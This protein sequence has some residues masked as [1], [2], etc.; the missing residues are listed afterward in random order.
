MAAVEADHQD[1]LRGLG[2]GFDRPQFVAAQAQR[3]FH[4][5]VLAAFQRLHHIT[6]V[7]VVAGGDDDGV[8]VGVVEHP[9]RV[10]IRILSPD[11]LLHRLRRQPP[12]RDHAPDVEAAGAGHRRHQ[13]PLGEVAG[14]DDAEADLAG[15]LA[16]RFRCWFVFLGLAGAIG[17]Y[18]ADGKGRRLADH[19]VIGFGRPL[20]RE[21]VRGQDLHVE[22]A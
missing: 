4:E 9:A 11:A 22:R 1:P 13:H 21:A 7:A 2:R 8:D 12:G 19:Q 14:A 6:R 18:D 16:P 15:D 17:E 3:L 20:D 5:H 10:G